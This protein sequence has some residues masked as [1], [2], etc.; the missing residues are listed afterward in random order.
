VSS[1]A[2]SLLR[3]KLRTLRPSVANKANADTAWRYCSGSSKE[4]P[5]RNMRKPTLGKYNQC[6][7]TVALSEMMLEIGK[8]ATKNQLAP[9]TRT[10]WARPFLT[11]PNT[12]PANTNNPRI[13][14][15]SASIA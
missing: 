9:N 7:A 14:K 10:A 4:H 6:S 15:Y 3:T 13:D 8:Y 12:R 11:L 1:F 2:Q 5:K